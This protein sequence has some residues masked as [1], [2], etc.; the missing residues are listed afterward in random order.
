M[1][2]R[3]DHNIKDIYGI[4]L[5][6]NDR[7]IPFWNS[8]L[9]KNPNVHINT[10]VNTGNIYIKNN[11]LEFI[12][13]I[14]QKGYSKF[15]TSDGGFDYSTDFNK[16]EISS[17]KLIFCEIFISMN[18][19]AEGGNFIINSANSKRILI[20]IHNACFCN[21]ISF[22]TYYLLIVISEKE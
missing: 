18:I 8:D 5:L 17:Y 16:Q 12:N 19:Q 13:N 7:R 6:T 9:V 4:T 2:K 20:I 21:M 1:G 15:I 11:S 3:V 10:K 22:V 14:K